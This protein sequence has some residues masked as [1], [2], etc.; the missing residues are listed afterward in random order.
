MS[1]I[2]LVK[3]DVVQSGIY[4]NGHWIK[5]SED[6][7]VYNPSTGENIANITDGNMDHAYEAIEAADK[8]FYKWSNKAPIERTAYLQRFYELIKSNASE[9]AE[10]I[11]EEQG[12]PFPDALGEVNKGAEFVLWF[13]EEAK[14]IGGSTY[15]SKEKNQ[16]VLTEKEPIGVVTAITPWNLP[17]GMILRKISPALAAG[18]TV[19]LKP[20]HETPLSA[21]RLVSL[22]EEA[23][24]PAGV[25][26]L[27]TTKQEKIVGNLLVSHPVVRAVTFTGSTQTGFEIQ[28]NS[29]N[30]SKKLIMELGGHAPFIVFD[31]YDLEECVDSVIKSKF[32]NSGQ[33]CTSVNMLVLQ[34]SISEKFINL[35]SKKLS[36]LEQK[37]VKEKQFAPL[38]NQQAVKKVHDH[39]N[40]ALDNGA[41][42][43]YGNRNLNTNSLFVNP[44]VLG[45][46]TPN[47]VITQQE[48]FGP[49]LP[50][51]TFNHENEIMDIVSLNDYGLIAYIYTSNIKRALNL[52]SQLRYGIIGINN[53]RPTEIQVPFGGFYSSGFGKEGGDLGIEEFLLSKSIYINSNY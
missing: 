53:S 20:S 36:L 50:V 51:F 32:R 41:S 17:V 33:T 11:N 3:T 8:A 21:I 48:T 40:D 26:N 24:F 29:S 39:I 44:I 37:D 6:F 49:V 14:R 7:N 9:L 25:I 1:N 34:E 13:I 47:M 31:D 42:V 10:I 28:K 45:D 12:K 16:T 23:R 52:Q 43:L 2:A 38:I 15:S 19:I 4:I 30:T 22:M 46:I 18:C 5:H 27:V 35:L